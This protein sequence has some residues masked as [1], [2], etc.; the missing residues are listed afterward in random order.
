MS[1]PAGRFALRM[2]RA[3]HARIIELAKADGV[4]A[5]SWIVAAVAQYVAARNIALEA[6]QLN[7]YCMLIKL[8]DAHAI[9]CFFD[10]HTPDE[11]KKLI[12]ARVDNLWADF[13]VARREHEKS[14]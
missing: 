12:C 9:D 2:P 4:S 6:K 3:L 5:N 1:S 8:F 11:F 10:G 14:E 13:Q 7:D